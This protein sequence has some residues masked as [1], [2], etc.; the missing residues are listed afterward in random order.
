MQDSLSLQILNLL[1]FKN[2]DMFK[3]IMPAGGEIKSRN[4]G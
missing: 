4:D 2:P 1:N 3:E